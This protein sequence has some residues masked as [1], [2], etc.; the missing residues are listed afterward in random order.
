MALERVVIVYD[1]Y[2]TK[3]PALVLSGDE[4]MTV[5]TG[6]GYQDAGAIAIDYDDGDITS[7]IT[8]QNDVN[9]SVAGTYAV[10]YSVLDKDGN[11]AEAARMVTVL[12]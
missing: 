1:R 7:K 10:K 6:S 11:V 4:I 12:E 9:T 2:R 5:A 3:G 8:V